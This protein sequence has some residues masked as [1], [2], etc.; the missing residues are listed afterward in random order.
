MSCQ[1]APGQGVSFSDALLE[2]WPSI[3]HRVTC[4]EDGKRL[5]G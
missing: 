5:E 1:S 2:T 3:L 4:V